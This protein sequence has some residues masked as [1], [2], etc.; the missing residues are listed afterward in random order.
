VK[1]YYLDDEAAL[2]DIFKEFVEDEKTEVRTFCD[3]QS[4]IEH[5]KS[6]PPCLAFI[7]YR[8]AQTSGDR[9][10]EKIAPQIPKVLVT[11]ELD[12]P[13]SDLFIE[14][15]RKPYKLYRIREII[16]NAR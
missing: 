6:A 13:S 3:A 7:D 14:I 1:V 12:L 15:I 9:I 5:C 10:A 16:E 11:G 2:C 4:F 8:L